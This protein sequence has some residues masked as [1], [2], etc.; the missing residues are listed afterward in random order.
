ML[1][2]S[3]MT[4]TALVT[5]TTLPYYKLLLLSRFF[6][7]EHG[8]GVTATYAARTLQ[9]GTKRSTICAGLHCVQGI[10]ASCYRDSFVDQSL[11]RFFTRKA[12]K[13]IVVL[14]QYGV[15]FGG[16][17]GVQGITFFFWHIV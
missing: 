17:R 3:N 13:G 15:F 10:A 4:K 6:V 14:F 11:L 1:D 16:G 8:R 9:G 5:Q 7:C 12:R 2:L